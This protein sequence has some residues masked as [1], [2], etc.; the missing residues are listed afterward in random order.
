[1][2]F[3]SY[4]IRGNGNG[5]VE[6]ASSQCKRDVFE[7]ET[8]SPIIVRH[9]TRQSEKFF[10]LFLQQPSQE[11]VR[12]VRYCVSFTPLSLPSTICPTSQTISKLRVIFVQTQRAR[13]VTYCNKCKSCRCYPECVRS[14][15][16]VGMCSTRNFHVAPYWEQR[17]HG[18]NRTG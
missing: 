17:W 8:R 3:E 10:F 11:M 6:S 14:R 4:R 13:R 15:G 5:I 1:M 2:A 12:S 16:T 9:N 18:G 7:Y